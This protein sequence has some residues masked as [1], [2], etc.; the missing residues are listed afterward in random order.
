MG[1]GKFKAIHTEGPG[2]KIKFYKK[3]KKSQIVNDIKQK[4]DSREIVNQK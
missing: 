3:N 1:G 2:S 4:G